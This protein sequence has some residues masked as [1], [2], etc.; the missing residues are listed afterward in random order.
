[1]HATTVTYTKAWSNFTTT[2]FCNAAFAGT[3]RFRAGKTSFRL[4]HLQLEKG[5]NV[6]DWS[7]AEEDSTIALEITKDSLSSTISKSSM[8]YDTSQIDDKLALCGEGAPPSSSASL[9]N[10]KYYLDITT[11][12][13]Y[14]SN[15][16][17]WSQQS[18]RLS[19]V[20][21]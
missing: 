16:S 15:G 19:L 5:A 6:T 11:G 13:Y 4:H 1:V 17:T 2:F 18:P 9:Y 14:L 3:V 7:A 12:F 20:K 10:G 8:K 21:A